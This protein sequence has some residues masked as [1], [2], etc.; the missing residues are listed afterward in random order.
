MT[1]PMIERVA[2]KLCEL[3]GK[4]PGV[5]FDVALVNDPDAIW[6][7]AAYRDKARAAIEAMRLPTPG[8]VKAGNGS[9]PWNVTGYCEGTV[10]PV[11]QRSW[12]AMID[13]ALKEE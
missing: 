13:A 9:K 2:R 4:D 12:P 3:D 1:N 6:A 8:M 7:W 11:C 10:H 5:S